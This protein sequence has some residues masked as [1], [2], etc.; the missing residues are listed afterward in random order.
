MAHLL[1]IGGSDAGISAA[2]RAREVDPLL[3]V[4]VAVADGFPNYSI[5]GLPFYLSG[6]VA[7]WHQLA[8]RTAEEIK[9]QGIRLLL[10]HTARQI[11]PGRK[12]VQV[13][14]EEGSTT[15]LPYD[16]LVVA[17]GA[18]PIKPDIVGLERPGIFLLR[19][20]ADGFA[21]H[22]HLST[23]SARSAVVVGGGYIGVEMA[24]ALTRRG[25]TVTLVERGSTVLKTVD[26]AFGE[27]VAAELRRNGVEVLTGAGI[28][29]ITQDGAF[30][31]VRGNSVETK[32][33]LLLIGAGA[34]PSAELAKSAGAAVGIRNALK[35]TRRMET[36]LPHVYAAG[37]CTETWHAMLSR[38][39]YLPLGTT[40]HKQGRVAGENAAGGNREFAGSLG[41]QV[42]KVFDLAIARTGLNDIEAAKAGFQPLTVQATAWDHKA[43]YPHGRELRIRVTGD[44]ENRRL[45][46]AQ[47]I[48]DHRS[49]IAKRIDVY[50]AAIFNG[51]SVDGLNDLDLSY[52]PPL[53]TPWDAVQV[54]AQEWIRQAPNAARSALPR[55]WSE[56]V[57]A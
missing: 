30:L 41:T 27:I 34:L 29:T 25:L 57:T 54:A 18:T 49:D 5:C 51:M 13:S 32:G 36:S 7:D 55:Q 6:E 4:T 48:G 19:T 33:Q 10:G 12:T 22:R 47:I 39:T 53:G 28:H 11:H 3:E 43:Y 52:T 50:A 46:G 16:K 42:V 2:L 24:D 15:E 44:R 35:V 26:A 38:D 1:I 23:R 21:V 9:A 45:L 56:Q 20:M 14:A 8:H 40:A 17:T 37:D 31:A